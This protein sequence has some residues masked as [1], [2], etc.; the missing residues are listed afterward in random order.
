MTLLRDW[1]VLHRVRHEAAGGGAEGRA[2][3]QQDEAD[4]LESNKLP[5]LLVFQIC[6]VII[7]RCI[8]IEI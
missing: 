1:E 4:Q 6:R 8:D 5:L 7:I 3:G 2:A